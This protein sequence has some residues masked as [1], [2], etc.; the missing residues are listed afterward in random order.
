MHAYRGWRSTKLHLALITMALVTLV[1]SLAGFPTDQFGTYCFTVTSAA[2][3][4]SGAAVAER[5][6]KPPIP[7]VDPA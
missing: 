3:I 7:P 2:G 4:F 1:Y 6:S 5:F